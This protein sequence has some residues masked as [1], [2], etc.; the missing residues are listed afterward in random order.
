MTQNLKHNFGAGPCILA[1][2]VL[3]RAAEAVKSWDGTG[4][5]IL[6]VS[7]RSPQFEVVVRETENLVREL[8]NVPDD[9]SVLFLQGGASM[10]FC[11]VPINFLQRSKK[12]AAYLDAGHFGEKAIKEARL[13]GK[14]KAKTIKIQ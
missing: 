1:P 5:S 11:M 10:Q 12:E 2:A 14:I 13:I 8:L 6:E 9:Y 7:H 4:L 3:D